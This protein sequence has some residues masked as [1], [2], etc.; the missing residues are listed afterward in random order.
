MN[1]K[2]I[3]PLQ[4]DIE[5]VIK[6]KNPNLLKYLPSFVIRYL[7][8]I[9]HEDFL[10]AFMR[11]EKNNYGLD[12]VAAILN[13]FEITVK[14]EGLEHVN[15]DERIIIA[16]N[17]PLGGMDGIAL[18]HVAGKI[19]KDIQFP[20]N[21]IL[22][23]V[24]NLRELFVP[25]NKHGSNM[26]NARIIDKSFE[27]KVMMLYFPAGMVSRKRKGVIADLQWHKTFIRKARSYKRNIVPT[28]IKAKNSNWF[29][30]LSTWRTKLGIKANLEMLYLVDEMY[31]FKGKEISIKFGP[32]ISYEKF[33]RSK[34][35]LQWAQEIKTIVHNM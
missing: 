26:E 31:K 3:E 5:Q 11:E 18:M 27:S 4:I 28:Y 22:M 25:I 33:D 2:N 6:E 8:N 32:S 29:Y 23:N 20:V 7:K 15:P 9:I 30:G 35:D 10:N 17:H 19:R 34:N 12:F 1:P 16:A 13:R 24:P 21:D 14:V